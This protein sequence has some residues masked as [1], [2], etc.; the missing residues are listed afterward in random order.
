MANRNRIH[1]LRRLCGDMV[2]DQILE[3]I[4]MLMCILGISNN[5]SKKK[6]IE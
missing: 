1:R 4:N 6:E 2:F 3:S 5:F